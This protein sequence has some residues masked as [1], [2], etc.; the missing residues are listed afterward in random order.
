[1]AA[2]QTSKIQLTIQSTYT[3]PLDLSTVTSR[4]AKNYVQNLAN[5]SGAN[6]A[7]KVFADTRTLTTGANEDLDLAG[8]LTDAF[9]QTL[10][11][12]KVKALA[13]V[14]AVANTTTLTVTRPSSNG[15]PFLAAAGD[16]FALKPGGIF[17]LTDP[18]SAGIAIA[19]SS[20]DLINVAN[21]AGASA[22]Y[23][24]IVI[25]E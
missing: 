3:N 13:I 22:S 19:A 1:M 12:A 23:D 6:K 20:A 8:S 18:S 11:F 4:I 5:G 21:A 10:T 14:A 15:A 9:G 25:G 24:V 2:A 16:G 17:L 7:S